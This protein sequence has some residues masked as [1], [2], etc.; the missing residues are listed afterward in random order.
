MKLGHLGSRALTFTLFDPL[1]L[2]ENEMNSIIV[3]LFKMFNVF[4]DCRFGDFCNR[5]T[6]C[7]VVLLVCCTFFHIYSGFFH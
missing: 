7:V 2:S 5:E 6:K 3:E 1:I 4:T